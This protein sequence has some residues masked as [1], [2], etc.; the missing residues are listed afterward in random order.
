MGTFT[1]IDP[2]NLISMLR[3]PP[4]T[5]ISVDI[6]YQARLRSRLLAIM[7][8]VI[9]VGLL[10]NGYFYEDEFW[11]VFANNR[12]LY[13]ALGLLLALVVRGFVITYAMQRVFNRFG[14]LPM[15]FRYFNV[16]FEI[17]VPSVIIALLAGQA[18]PLNILVAPIAEIYFLF[19]LLSVL[20]MDFRL[21]L[22]SGIIAGAEYYAIALFYL[23]AVQSPENLPFFNMPQFYFGR[24]LILLLAGIV[25]GIVGSLIRKRV[26]EIYAEREQKNKVEQLFGQQLSV[27]VAREL[28][29]S[30]DHLAGK[31]HKVCIMFLD[32]R[33]FTPMMA[34]KD[35]RE[36]IAFQNAIFPFMID[37][38]YRRH[39]I[40]NQLLGDGFMATFGAP[41]SVGNDCRNAVNASVDILNELDARNGEAPLYATKIGIGLHY[42]PV[43]TGNVGSE[44]RK[45]Y[46]VTGQ[47]VIISSRIEA[48]NKQYGSSLLLSGNVLE[49]LDE[50]P[51]KPVSLGP[52]RLKGLDNPI[53]IFKLTP[54]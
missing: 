29:N 18:N 40:I 32:I 27:E 13:L 46:S 19:I 25:A 38:V 50:V 8:A 54:H 45:Q 30:G 47:T 44:L 33:G 37:I 1:R 28:M 10:V 15:A 34:G 21:S 14:I 5:P 42:G 31:N 12:Y 51:G 6:V 41:V 23:D 2:V 52:V 22:F 3:S 17:T 53:E 43:V 11:G 24:T 9:L 39:G 7:V 16:F 48:L 49:K 20:E 36:I 35:P 26:L 4:R